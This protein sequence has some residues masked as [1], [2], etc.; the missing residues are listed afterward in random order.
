MLLEFNLTIGYQL[1]GNACE[2]KWLGRSNRNFKYLWV[3]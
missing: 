1:E 3:Y 2:L